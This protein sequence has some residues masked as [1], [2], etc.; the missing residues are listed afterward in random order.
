[1][2]R[3]KICGITNIEDALD[4]VAFGAD[5]IGVIGNVHVAT[6]R[7]IPLEKCREIVSSVPVFVSAVLVMMPKSLE[8]AVHAYNEVMP[9]AIQLHGEESV[10]FIKKLKVKVKAKII[11]AVHVRNKKDVKK[12]LEYSEICDAIVLDTFSEN[13][14]GSGKKHDWSISREIVKA[15]STPVIL[16]GGLNL[17]NVK[18]AVE[19]VKP[20]AVDVSSGVE[21]EKGKKNYRLVKEFIQRAKEMNKC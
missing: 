15:V 12:A 5:A 18:E 19:K 17:G 20:Y 1:M 16:A 14:G 4:C 3:V 9:S 21:I 13:L 10:E 11:K 6:P 2:V 7:K 8:E